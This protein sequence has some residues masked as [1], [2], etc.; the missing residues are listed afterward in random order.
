MVLKEE[1]S[2]LKMLV[3]RS[4]AMGGRTPPASHLMSPVDVSDPSGSHH[5]A[6]GQY[7]IMSPHFM[8]PVE[9]SNC[10][11]SDYRVK[12]S[13]PYPPPPHHQWR[14]ATLFGY[15]AGS[16]VSRPSWVKLGPVQNQISVSVQLSAL[17]GQGEPVL[18]RAQCN[19]SS[20]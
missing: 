11:G 4:A 1:N 7:T 6:K 14:S 9:V 13:T 12:V 10:L 20:Q 3:R 8:S 2:Y 5:R 15:I 17:L 19:Y 16:K 18:Y